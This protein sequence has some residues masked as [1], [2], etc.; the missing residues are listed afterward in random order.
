MK[1]I[2]LILFLFISLAQHS[3]ALV[4][5]SVL[6]EQYKVYFRLART[7]VDSTYLSNAQTLQQLRAS[8]KESSHA[9]DSITIVSY[10][11]PEGPYWL[12]KRYAEQ[13]GYSVYNYL[14]D[15]I[16]LP[17]TKETKWAVKTNLLYDAALMPTIEVEY[18]L[19]SRWSIGLEGGIAWWRNKEQHK[20]YH[21]AHLSPEVRYWFRHSDD[22]KK[23]HYVG[24]FLMGGLYDWQNYDGYKGEF[25]AAGLSY[26]YMFPIARRLSL[27]LG[28]GIGVLYTK[29]EEY[30]PEE[31]H[32]VYQ[33]TAHT[34]YVGP[35]KGKISLVWHFDEVALNRAMRWLKGGS[36]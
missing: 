6:A 32:Y 33:Q 25:A 29:Y 22:F 8:L 2:Y 21:V 7:D 4:K 20:Y 13:R 35:V 27:E 10:S 3:W 28:L 31:G 12:N 24:S 15:T 30:L 26:G 18:Y 11:S 36:Q 17:E 34:T 19:T 5:D 1:K 16:A 9:L 14:Q 23:G